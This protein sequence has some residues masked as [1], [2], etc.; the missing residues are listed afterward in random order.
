MTSRRLRV[1]HCHQATGEWTR[2]GFDGLVIL[3]SPAFGHCF[4]PALGNVRDVRGRSDRNRL[5]LACSSRQSHAYS[6]LLIPILSR[7]Y[8]NSDWCRLELALMHHRETLVGYRT[9]A[10]D[11]VLILLLAT[12]DTTSL[13]TQ[14]SAYAGARFMTSQTLV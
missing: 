7:D 4:G 2:S 11:N 5:L 12:D 6:R 8:F 13:S 9:P 1:R 14:A 3:S 10:Q